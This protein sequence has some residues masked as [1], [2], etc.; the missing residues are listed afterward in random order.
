[1]EVRSSIPAVEEYFSQ[2]GEAIDKIRHRNLW[3]ACCAFFERSY[4]WQTA[5]S[6]F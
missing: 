5:L 4:N 2:F 1:M 6:E 3:D